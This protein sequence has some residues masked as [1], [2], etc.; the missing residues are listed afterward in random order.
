M[1]FLALLFNA[2]I[3]RWQ[4]A[5]YGVVPGPAA[6]VADLLPIVGRMRMVRAMGEAMTFA[7][8]AVEAGRPLDTSLLEAAQLSSNIWLRRRINQWIDLMNRGEL[9]SE[10]ARKAGMPRMVWGMLATAIQTP[11][12]APVLHFL[13]RYYSTRFSRSVALLEASLAPVAAIVMGFF[14]CLL[15]LS[16]FAPLISLI[17]TVSSPA[18]KR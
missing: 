2:V 16:V 10:A 17:Q 5:G 4:G 18:S 14:V 15:A 8:D 6:R 3:T 9:P 11:D 13:G 12:L 1:I 7:A